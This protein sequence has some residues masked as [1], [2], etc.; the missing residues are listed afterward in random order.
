[1]ELSI[2]ETQ[3]VNKQDNDK[4]WRLD[5]LVRNNNGKCILFLVLLIS[6]SNIFHIVKTKNSEDHFHLIVGKLIKKYITT[7]NNT[8]D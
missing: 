7:R 6:F 8:H 5:R 1:M 3:T 4:K 2:N